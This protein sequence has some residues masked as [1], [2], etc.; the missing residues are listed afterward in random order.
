MTQPGVSQHLKKL[1]QQVGQALIG[2]QGKS[3]NCTPAGEAVFALGLSRRAEEKRMRAAI[4]VDDKDVGTVRIACSGI[5]AMLLYPVPMPWIG[6]APDLRIHLEAAPQAYILAGVLDGRFDLGV[7]G[8]DPGH[9]RLDARHLGRE[10]LC[11]VLPADAPAAALTFADLEA[12]GF[13]AIPTG[14]PMPTTC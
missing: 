6:A 3:F 5:F 11:L 12:R 13:I 1:E 10:E 9:A 14:M 2:R 7:L 4:E 8:A